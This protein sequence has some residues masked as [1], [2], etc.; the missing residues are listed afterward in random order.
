MV[1]LVAISDIIILLS[2]SVID[3]TVTYFTMKKMV[4]RDG[5]SSYDREINGLARF[6]WSKFGLKRGTIV[7]AL[8][9]LPLLAILS[10]VAPDNFFWTMTG[11]Y[12]VI[13]ML[14]LHNYLLLRQLSQNDSQKNGKETVQ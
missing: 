7:A 10:Y 2:F 5:K 12:I 1:V 3:I 6:C 8:I 4:E 13:F 11:A 9:V 14:H